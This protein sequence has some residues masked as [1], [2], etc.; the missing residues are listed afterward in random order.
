MT[1]I[2]HNMFYLNTALTTWSPVLSVAATNCVGL[3]SPEISSHGFTLHL[4]NNSPIWY[5][6]NLNSWKWFEDTLN[7]DYRGICAELFRIFYGSL[8]KTSPTPSFLITQSRKKKLGKNPLLLIILE[9][10][11]WTRVHIHDLLIYPT[12]TT[13][14][15]NYSSSLCDKNITTN[16]VNSFFTYTIRQFVSRY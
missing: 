3:G 4:Y 2:V 11:P 1:K 10:L 12:V 5:K 16:D 14:K 8:P 7:Y 6:T 9:L 13:M 15:H